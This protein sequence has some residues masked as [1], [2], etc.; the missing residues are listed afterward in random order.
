MG[1]KLLLEQSGVGVE[2]SR[3]KYESGDWANLIEEAWANGQTMK[4][5]RRGLGAAGIGQRMKEVQ[6]F[7]STLSSWVH[8]QLR[9]RVIPNQITSQSRPLEANTSKHPPFRMS[10]NA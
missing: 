3:E 1:L 10:M 4:D 8:N 2:I 5:E 7:A 9:S 6:Q